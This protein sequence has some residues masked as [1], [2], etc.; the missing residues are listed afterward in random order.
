MSRWFRVY[1]DLVNDPKVQRLPDK[2]FKALINL[3]CLASANDGV[4]PQTEDIAFVLRM[5]TSSVE[6]MISAL[7]NAGLFDKD[8]T[9]TRP[10][11]WSGRQFKSDVSTD[12]VKRHRNSR[13][14]V[15]H[16]LQETPPDT[17]TEAEAETDPEIPS[18]REGIAPARPHTIPDDWKPKDPN[19]NP[20]EVSRFKAD[21]KARGIKRVDWDAE[22][23]LWC[24]RIAD[25]GE[26][27][28]PKATSPPAATTWL[29][30]ADPRWP[31]LA[32]RY[33]RER[34]KPLVA[35]R[36][37]HFPDAGAALP[38]EWLEPRPH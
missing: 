32:E 35:I 21:R 30:A 12:R 38:T 6:A 3:W 37:K 7:S 24:S 33:Q 34:G 8:E 11:N 19:A 20:A 26:A 1:D 28:Q 16:A 9:G 2:H 36:S 22:W 14:N 25:Y 10:H 13:R 17:E 23:D 27:V 4:L 5:P 31:A 18:L 15:S 29:E